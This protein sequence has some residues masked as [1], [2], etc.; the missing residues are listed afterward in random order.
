MV[1]EDKLN[2]QR[3]RRKDPALYR[4][5]VYE[6][7][8]LFDAGSSHKAIISEIYT[9][10]EKNAPGYYAHEGVPNIT[11]TWVGRHIGKAREPEFRFL[12]L[13]EFPDTTLLRTIHSRLPVSKNVHFVLAPDSATLLR[14]A[15]LAFDTMLVD[16][17][18]SQPAQPVVVSVSGGRTM[19]E[20]ARA[21]P[22]FHRDM[23]W[24]KSGPIGQ[25]KM[26]QV[27]VYSLTS[28]GVRDNIEALSDTVAAAIA[29][30]LGVRAHGLLG[31]AIFHSAGARE[32]FVKDPQ[33]RIHM[34]RV[35]RSSIILTS[36]GYVGD[37]TSLTRQVLESIDSGCVSKLLK[38]HP[39]LADILYDCVDGHTGELVPLPAKIVSRLF[40]VMTCADLRR[41]VKDDTQCLVV[42]SGY[43][44][45]RHA[46]RGI[47]E[48][49]MASDIHLDLECARGLIDA[50]PLP[51]P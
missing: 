26:E 46:L 23:Q 25:K 34:E 10:A 21:A 8:R 12:Q 3:M 40:S 4:R 14:Q 6:V 24:H 28:G 48:Q 7:A 38:T 31:P 39:H 44:K 11:P 16:R 19:L 37:G 30:E 2:W 20:L 36:V 15:W 35:Q 49:R 42:A 45:G 32:A 41:M 51:P 29:R 33:V 22:R 17:I 9:W 50:C 27:A 13:A 43:E 18:N 47:V 5:L 1:A